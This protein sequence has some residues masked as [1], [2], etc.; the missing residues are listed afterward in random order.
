MKTIIIL[1]TSCLF[2]TLSAS[3]QVS[4][5]RQVIGSTGNFSTSATMQ[6]SSTVG[7]AVTQTLISGTLVLTQGFQQPDRN[8]WQTGT[9]DLLDLVVSYEVFPNPTS[10]LLTV[11]LESE[12]RVELQ[13]QMY[14]LSGK[15]LAGLDKNLS[16]QGQIESQFSLANL[17][18]GIYLL[19]FLDA[20]GQVLISH[21]IRKQ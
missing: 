12:K 13:L 8:Y 9:E 11:R 20:E 19:T 3:A 17:A 15:K 4:L 16:G 14:E 21:K 10:D 18:E 2:A 1:L 6:L 7:E 5:E